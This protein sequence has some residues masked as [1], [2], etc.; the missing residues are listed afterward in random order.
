MNTIRNYLDNMF[1]GLPQTEDVARAKKE[2]L[3]M[4]EDKYN[5][6]KN[7]GK[8][9]NEAIGI[10]ISE[11]GN[12]DELGD[13][14]GIKQV[15]ENKT[16]IHLVTY[17]E[18][19]N[20]IEESRAA[21]PKTALGV[22]LCI[23]SPVTLLL[24]IGLKELGV[25]GVKEELLIAAGLVILIC[26]VATGVLHFIRY[27]SKLEKYEYLKFNVFELDYKAEEMV[28]NIQK[29]DE[30][31]YKAAVSISVVC[32]ILSALPVIVTPLVSEIDGLSVIAVT[33]TLIIVALSTYNLINKSS[34]YEPC[35]VL[36]QQ[37]IIL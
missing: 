6:L 33:I 29:Q 1:L 30:P 16:D 8:T 21:A 25:V 10:V 11:F 37:V 4:M 26:L 22:L 27:T 35:N 5:E 7:E 15:I 36:L 32:Y 9:E 31:T 19:K 3:A 23:I 13:T 34:Y 24:L 17:E 18:A 14:L 12:L 28:Q 20:Y 2:L